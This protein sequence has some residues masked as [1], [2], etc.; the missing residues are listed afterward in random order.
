MLPGWGE[1][2]QG[3]PKQTGCSELAGLK[4]RWLVPRPLAP[5]R[6][7]SPFSLN[8]S[9]GAGRAEVIP[10]EEEP[11]VPQPLQPSEQNPGHSGATRGARRCARSRR[12]GLVGAEHSQAPL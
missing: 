5:A 6:T 4:P 3:V 2:G 11:R 8:M 7:P 9:R 1:V 10:C 12:T